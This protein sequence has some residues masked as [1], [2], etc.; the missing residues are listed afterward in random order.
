[1]PEAARQ[2]YEFL[3]SYSYLEELINNGETEG[4]YLEC[5]APVSPQLTRDMK[6]NLARAI[7]GFSNTA[8]GRF[9]WVLAL[10][11][12]TTVASMY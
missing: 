3:D 9:F 4:I 11:S 10:R 6:A 8:G 2:L 7:S 1:M 12:M 5:K